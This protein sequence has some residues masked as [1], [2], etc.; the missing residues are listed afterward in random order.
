MTFWND[1]VYPVM[2]ELCGLLF[3]FAFIGNNT[4]DWMTLRRNFGLF[5]IVKTA[6]DYG[7]F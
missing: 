4:S 7:A 2:F 5:N 6:I 1:S 3:D